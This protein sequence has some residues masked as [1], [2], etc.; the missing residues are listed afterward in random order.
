MKKCVVC[1]MLLAIAPIAMAADTDMYVVV[2]GQGGPGAC[3]PATAAN[4][5][6]LLYLA[7]ADQTAAINANAGVPVPGAYDVGALTLRMDVA[8]KNNPATG[9]EIISSIGLNIDAAASGGTTPLSATALT[10]TDDNGSGNPAWSG[11]VTGTLNV[12]GSLVDD[13]RMVAVPPSSG[14]ALWSDG[15]APGSGYSV[16]ALDLA[17]GNWDGGVGSYTSYAVSLVVG[18]LKITRVVDPTAGPAPGV[19]NVSFGYDAG[20]SLDASV[21]GSSPGSS[22]ANAD[23]TVSIVKKGDLGSI[24]QSTGDFVIGAFDSVVDFDD[25][26]NAYNIFSGAYVPTGAEQA[27]YDYT[28]DFGTINQSTG[29]FDQIPDCVVDFD[30]IIFGYNFAQGT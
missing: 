5:N 4:S 23:A 29:D 17:A 30:D 7:P 3:F 6:A 16:A 22:S 28:W 19:E 2:S 10:V 13:A 18:D 12:G 25:V 1:V 8:A 24:D 20:G 9:D 26:I 27:V 14:H 21:S 11:Y 15:Y